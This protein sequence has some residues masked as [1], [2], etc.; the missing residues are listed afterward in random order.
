LSVVYFASVRA[1][2]E[3]DNKISK[4][5]RLFDAAGMAE[6]AGN[7]DLAAVKVHFGER[8]ADAYLNPVLVRPVV[9]RLLSIGAR[10]FV[11]DTNTLYG[12]GR[13][14]SADHLKTAIEHG[15]CCSVVGAPVII[16]DGLKS[17]SF[18][19]V[20][21]DKK[22]FKSVKIAGDIA[23]ADSLIVLS[24]F[25]GH[26]LSGFGGA[27]KNLGMGCSPAA[28]KAEQHASRPVL[29]PEL[30]MGCGKCERVCPYM[31][32]KVE[33]KIAGIDHDACQGCGECLRVCPSYAIDF[34]WLVQVPPFLERMAEYALGAVLGKQG[35]VGF[36]NFLL[37]I[38]PDCDCLPW[39]DSSIV[40]DIGILASK[41]PVAL[42]LASY[43]LV[44]SKVGLENSLLRHNHEPGKDKFKGIWV[45]TD[46]V[47]LLKYA[48]SIGLGNSD[49]KLI[50]IY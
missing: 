17:Q 16:A 26:I 38:T 22:H 33:M 44:N 6:V 9:D 30:C 18:S 2:T 41:D 19:E 42:D 8:G 45:Y 39:S 34:D 1:R 31:A 12:G 21:I 7:G 47:H 28:G 20:K 14:N 23:S 50:E 25:K 27:I 5:Q 24:H 29:N 36:F 35:K 15:F 11:T 40:P 13:A 43:D 10:P 37:N 48:A 32:I 49:Y 3:R 46:G 4:V